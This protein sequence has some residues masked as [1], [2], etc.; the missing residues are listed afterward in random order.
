MN[1]DS[2]DLF[3]S[4]DK[5]IDIKTLPLAARMRP[6]SLDE[7]AGQAHIIGQGKLLR[8]AIESDRLTSL[9][10][11]GPPGSGKTSLAYCIS[12]V[13]KSEFTAVNATVSNVE[14]LRKIILKAKHLKTSSGRKT[15]LFI[16]EIHRFN[17]AQQDVLLPDVEENNIV[18]IGATVHNP[19]FSLVAPLLSRSLVFELKPLS[20]KEILTILN[21][22]LQDKER[23]LGNLKVKAQ[24]RLWSF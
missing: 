5:S 17:K 7:Y 13:T 6:R 3:L 11:Y 2:E 15:I 21:N 19:F 22:A 20:Q 18:L 16:D 24:K 9:I 12:S 4:Q 8:R 23:G 10:L 14:E 1:A